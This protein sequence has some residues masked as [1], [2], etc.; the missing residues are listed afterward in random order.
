MNEYFA[1]YAGAKRDRENTGI[2]TRKEPT[3]IELANTKARVNAEF[4]RL[5]KSI[6]A[7]AEWN[8]QFDAYE[9]PLLLEVLE[10]KRSEELTAGMSMNWI[11]SWQA[12]GRARSIL[13]TDARATV[14]YKA[15]DE[16][17][18]ASAERPVRYFG[19]TDEAGFRVF[20]FG[21]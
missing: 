1:S 21:R 15:H 6:A 11:R 8:E 12:N 14:V 7:R 13:L 3:A 20:L 5:A 4:D 19:F 10:E 2:E 18:R 17:R 16:R 9:I